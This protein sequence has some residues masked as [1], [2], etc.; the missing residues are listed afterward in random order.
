MHEE[1]A[2]RHELGMMEQMPAL[3]HPFAPSRPSG[4]WLERSLI[5]LLYCY[6][7]HPDDAGPQPDQAD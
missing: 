4:P 1:I 2:A 6:T 5:N 3:R 7:G